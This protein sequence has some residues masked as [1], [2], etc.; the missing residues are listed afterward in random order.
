M[1]SLETPRASTFECPK[2]KNLIDNE[3]DVKDTPD[4]P[5]GKETETETEIASPPHDGKTLMVLK[6]I[7]PTVEKKMVTQ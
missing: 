4:D 3:G 6:E 7:A 1:F 5:K 2:H